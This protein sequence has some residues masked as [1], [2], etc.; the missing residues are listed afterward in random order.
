MNMR[1][2]QTAVPLAEPVLSPVNRSGIDVPPSVDA[3]AVQAASRSSP[4]TMSLASI[5]S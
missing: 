4:H 1:D 5:G 3:S 2:P